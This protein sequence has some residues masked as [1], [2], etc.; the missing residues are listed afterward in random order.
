MQILRDIME[1]RG[2]QVA[3]RRGEKQQRPMGMRCVSKHGPVQVWEE[4]SQV[5]EEH[6]TCSRRKREA[7]DETR[8]GTCDKAEGASRS[9]AVT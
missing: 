9:L 1:I 5:V 3:E 2:S 6:P 7:E 4:S 8:R